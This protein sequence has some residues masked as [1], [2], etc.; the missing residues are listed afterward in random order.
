M[1]LDDM[2]LFVQ[3][4]QHGSFTKAAEYCELP[5]S[6]VSRRIR[7][8]EDSLKT[9]LLERTTRSLILT[10][11]GEAFYHKATQILDDV[12]AT[13]KD[14]AHR[15]GDYTGKLTLY[16]PDCIL[17]LCTDHISEF[18]Q[19]YPDLS[20]VIHSTNQPLSAMADRRFD[21]R[22][23]IGSQPDS[24]FIAIPLATLHYDYFASPGYLDTHGIPQTPA[25]FEQH[26][27]LIMH[28]FSSQQLSW[29]HDNVELPAMPK[30]TADSPYVL[31]ALTAAGQG[32]GCLPLFMAVDQ[33]RNIQ[34][35][36]LFDGQF[37]FPLTI[38][39]VYHSRRFVP[40]KVRVLIKD[41]Q[42]FLQQ[43][44]STIE[45]QLPT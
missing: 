38:Y 22:I 20:L 8:L 45:G 19:Q 25:E 17:E 34:L 37:C 18:C 7:N 27:T 6:T 32:V 33:V 41:I 42:Q 24:S 43:K 12:A 9:R 39:G 31:R 15:Q 26:H 11:V 13:E 30:C 1:N 44:L 10:E 35:V 16:A 2:A 40:S 3:V 23:D 21:L 29:D 5:K 4:V 36:R 28:Q 14:I